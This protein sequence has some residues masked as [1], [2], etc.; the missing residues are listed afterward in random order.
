MPKSSKHPIQ[1]F[2]GIVT[3]TSIAMILLGAAAIILPRAAGLVIGV[4]IGWLILLAGVAHLAHALTSY[5][6][7]SILW[8][9]LLGILYFLGGFYLILNPGLSLATSG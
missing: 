4:T 1:Q 3:T 8:R 5:A 7:G 6:L 2:S 9:S